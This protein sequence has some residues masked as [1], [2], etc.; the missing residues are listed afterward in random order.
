MNSGSGCGGSSNSVIQPGLTRVGWIGTGVMGA[1]MAARIQSAGYPLTIYARNPSKPLTL[2]LT[3]SGGANL[4]SSPA[5]LARSSDVVFTMLGHP[6]DVRSVLL[7]PA[8]GVLSAL[9]SGAAVVDTTSSHPD[10]A[11]EI[12]SAAASRNCHAVDAPVSGG[13]LGA[14]EGKLA[15]FA[16]GEEAVV[17]RLSPLFQILGKATHMGPPGSGQSAKIANQIAVSGSMLGLSEALLFA[18]RSGLDAKAF[19]DAIRGGA[20]G[21]NVMELFGE[22]MIRRDF[23][24][25]GFAEYL[26]KDLGMAISSSSSSN[27]ALSLMAAAA[28]PGTALFHQ[29]YLAMV[30]NGD[31]KLGSQGLISVLQRINSNAKAKAEVGTN[32]QKKKQQQQH[33]AA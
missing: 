9:P 33:H 11:R 23:R 2:S 10:L 13:D 1:A 21:S 8:T 32:E 6:S 28:L 29:L 20:A 12:A 3:Q 15:I 18:E 14:R 30:A 26:V 16:G 27:D 7:D 5:D 19:V 4:A 24:P 25:G 22:R 17:R 31:G